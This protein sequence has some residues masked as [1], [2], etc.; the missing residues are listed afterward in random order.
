MLFRSY[1]LAPEVI[2]RTELVT[3]TSITGPA[4]M[5]E[6]TVRFGFVFF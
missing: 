2:A 5:V 6:F 1:P 4:H 3:S